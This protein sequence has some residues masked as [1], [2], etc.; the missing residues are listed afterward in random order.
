MKAKPCIL[1]V[2]TANGYCLTPEKCTSIKSAIRKAKE[3]C[4]FAYRIYVG[5]ILV[6]RGFCN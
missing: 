2:N 3:S 5:K 1:I 6:A 4:G